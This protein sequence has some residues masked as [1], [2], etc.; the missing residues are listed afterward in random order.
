MNDKETTLDKVLRKI[1]NNPIL[2][3][4]ILIGT[5][6]IAISSFSTALRNISSFAKPRKKSLTLVNLTIINEPIAIRT[7]H[8]EW[9]PGTIGL[10]PLIDIKLLNSDASACF[11]KFIDFDIIQISRKPCQVAC[12]KIYP[13][14]WNYNLSLDAEKETDHQRLQISQAVP[15]NGV[16]RFVV[17]LGQHWMNSC[18][19]GYAEYNITLTLY[20]NKNSTLKL[21]KYHVNIDGPPGIEEISDYLLE[22]G[23]PISLHK[24]T[25]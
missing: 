23:G 22:H 19:C 10:F 21:G 13:S 3:G 2:A 16:D 18:D 15:G 9:L 12:E 7:F 20:Y 8:E 11:L 6:V 24:L 14:C 1:R 5:I 17:I 4:I 25:K